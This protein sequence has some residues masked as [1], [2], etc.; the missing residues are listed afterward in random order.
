MTQQKNFDKAISLYQNLFSLPTSRG[1]ILAGIIASLFFAFLV[2]P[3]TPINF[4]LQAVVNLGAWI[5][6]TLISYSLLKDQPTLSSRRIMGL[7]VITIILHGILWVIPLIIYFFIPIDFIIELGFLISL[8]MVIAVRLIVFSAI[9]TAKLSKTTTAGISYSLV[10]IVLVTTIFPLS[11]SHSLESATTIAGIFGIFLLLGFAFLWIVN[12]PAE[13]ALGIGGIQLFQGFA[14]EW[15]V[16]EGIILDNYF[17]EMGSPTTTNVSLYIFEREDKPNCG[18]VVP[19]IHPG[20]FKS[21]GSSTLSIKIQEQLGDTFATPHGPSTHEL[22]LVSKDETNRVVQI[23]KKQLD[24]AK[25]SSSQGSQSTRV[26]IGKITVLSQYF[27]NVGLYIA[28]AAPE[29]IDDI[30]QAVGLNALSKARE[31]GIDNG[32]F[33]DAHNCIGHYADSVYLNSPEADDVVNAVGDATRKGRILPQGMLKVG[34]SNRKPAE[35]TEEMGLAPGGITTY[36]VEVNN[37][38]TCYVVVDS[39]NAITGLR[40]KI[41]KQLLASGFDE[42]ELL[43]TDTH[44]ASGSLSS[45]IGFNPLGEGGGEDLIIKEILQCA[46]DAKDDLSEA[47]MKFVRNSIEVQTIGKE[48]LDEITTLIASSAKLA[49]RLIIILLGFGLLAAVGTY[50]LIRF[51]F[52]L[53]YGPY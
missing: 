22:N 11:Y 36:V 44:M 7:G 18:L 53:Y 5:T 42:A 35:I 6:S 41:R 15:L 8:G 48:N 38:Q 50:F 33:I 39:N 26:K 47:R 14:E 9:T 10:F 32:A 52:T 3:F 13:S 4:V 24:S 31:E 28:T 43:T 17:T 12:T 19:E 37:Q 25:I 1:L 20:P 16:G 49:K 51:L 29:E 23:I 40:D 45:K 34:V 27:G 30:S 21:I 46:Q 2:F